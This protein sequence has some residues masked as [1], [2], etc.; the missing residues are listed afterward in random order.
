[1]P[2]FRLIRLLSNIKALKTADF[3]SQLNDKSD[4]STDT[5]VPNAQEADRLKESKSI[6]FLLISPE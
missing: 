4:L 5:E 6:K 3:F 2:K 1:V